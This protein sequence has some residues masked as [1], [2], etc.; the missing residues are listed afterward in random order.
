M[1]EFENA[2]AFRASVEQRIRNASRVS[3]TPHDRLRK[4]IAFN[5]LV[6]RFVAARDDRW[7][8]KGGV[9]LLW[10]VASDARM[11]RDVSPWSGCDNGA[12]DDP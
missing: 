5:R 3:G 1:T 8:L 9:A 2:E 7:A 6:A 4:D 11:T 12:S 10:R